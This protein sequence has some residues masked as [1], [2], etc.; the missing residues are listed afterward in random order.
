MELHPVVLPDLPQV[1]Q[2]G[3]VTRLYRGERTLAEILADASRQMDAEDEAERYRADPIRY[4]T[5]QRSRRTL[6][7][8][9]FGRR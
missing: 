9:L 8:R 1:V 5:A 3:E 2:R 7:G 6:W 4:V